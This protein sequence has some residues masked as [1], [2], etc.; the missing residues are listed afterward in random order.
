MKEN[1][2]KEIASLRRAISG[3][4]LEL[5]N[6]IICLQVAGRNTQRYI[7]TDEARHV[8]LT[9]KDLPHEVPRFSKESAVE[10]VRELS[11]HLLAPDNDVE[12]RLVAVPYRAEVERV[13]AEKE[14]FLGLLE[15]HPEFEELFV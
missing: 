15:K 4:S 9:R 11:N 8:Y 5:H 7:A 3:S 12:S 14:D 10:N 2:Q 1:L 13:L 6:H